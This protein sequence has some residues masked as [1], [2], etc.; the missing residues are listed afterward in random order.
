M[1]Q[2][3]R[4]YYLFQFF[5]SLLLWLPIFYEFQKL[6]GLSDPEI[7]A[8]QSIY[9]VVFALLEVPTGFLADRFGT[10]PCLK[11]GAVTLTLANALPILAPT[12]GGMLSHFIFIA[13]ARSLVSGA[14]SAYLYNYL[15]AYGVGAE[16]K[17]TEGMARSLSLIGKIACFAGVGF[18]MVLDK[19]L[20][21]TLTTLASA[22][23]VYYAWRLPAAA[24]TNPPTQV[25]FLDGFRVL[26]RTP[27][28]VLVML[29]GV[30]LFVMVR[31][32]QVNLFQ[33]ILQDKAVTVALYGTVMGV[34][35]GFE[36]LGSAGPHWL[37][38]WLDDGNAIFVLTLVMALALAVIPFV[39][40]G[41]TIAALCVF[42][43]VSGFS[44]P[45][46]R[47]LINDSIPAG[48]QR[49]S[50]IS[51]ESIVDRSV[52]AVVAMA[53]GNY[54]AAGRL[55]A[56]LLQSAAC[57]V[58]AMAVLFFAMRSHTLKRTL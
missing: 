22:V 25:R 8:I 40:M 15:H 14:S 6:I 30:A 27:F 9:Y 51:M 24:E 28:L 34:M 11:A 26:R 58:I 48:S 23:A 43:L 41:G 35:T 50:L 45:I 16:Y 3:I 36:A 5:F 56:F 55:D 52:C 1:K 44:F 33:P 4:T 57:I 21:Y 18:L 2:G 54:L 46:Q 7:F 12:Y 53:I 37:K 47:Q 38:R 29:Q 13:L 19:T 31:I 17:R 20:P 10:R 32:V 39:G 42:A 49:A